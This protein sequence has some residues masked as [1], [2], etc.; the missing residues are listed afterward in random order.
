MRSVGY[1]ALS[2]MQPGHVPHTWSWHGTPPS[3]ASR[4]TPRDVRAAAERRTSSGG[5]SYLFVSQP[6]PSDQPTH[7]TT[8]KPVCMA[9]H[10]LT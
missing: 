10:I 1:Q 4:A 7:S 5:F 2:G 8:E 3:D 9:F 6:P